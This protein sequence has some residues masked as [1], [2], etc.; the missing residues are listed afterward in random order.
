MLRLVVCHPGVVLAGSTREVIV[1]AHGEASESAPGRW[2]R[3][4]RGNLPL[5]DSDPER[6]RSLRG[7]LGSDAIIRTPQFC[8]DI[9]SAV[10]TIATVYTALP[11][12]EA[13]SLKHHNQG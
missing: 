8:V 6:D 10:R 4:E 9:P 2:A 7:P 1:A 3:V 13:R 11:T 12:P 5:C